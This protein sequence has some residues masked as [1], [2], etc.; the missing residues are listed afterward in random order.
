MKNE[1]IAQSINKNMP[2]TSAK[3]RML[4]NIK[5]SKKK[6][7]WKTAVALTTAA[8][9]FVIAALVPWNE[10]GGNAFTVSVFATEVQTS[11]PVTINLADLIDDANRRDIVVITVDAAALDVRGS[12][13]NPFTLEDNV[14]VVRIDLRS[15]GTNIEKV[16]YAVDDGFFVDGRFHSEMGG[17][18]ILGSELVIDGNE[19]DDDFSLNFGMRL[20]DIHAE[21]ITVSV[22]STFNDG[23]LAERIINIELAEVAA[24]VGFDDL[25]DRSWVCPTV[26]IRVYDEISTAVRELVAPDG[27]FAHLNIND[28]GFVVK[29]VWNTN[30]NT[31]D[32]D[33]FTSLSHINEGESQVWFAYILE[34]DTPGSVPVNEAGGFL[35]ELSRNNDDFTF[36]FI[37]HVDYTITPP[38]RRDM[39]IQERLEAQ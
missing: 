8:A 12:G 10:Q 36:N 2:S 25:V 31:V 35:F 1:R 27:E 15:W 33:N 13:D 37:E 21:Q 38:P 30:A 23:S 28:S 29:R 32:Y 11:E 26:Y 18:E 14:V 7:K 16:E 22:T 5:H 17:V 39:M 6:P 24:M 20:S 19:L 3:E 34:L 9:V 4:M